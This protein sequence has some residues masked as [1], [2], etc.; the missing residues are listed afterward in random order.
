M[1]D[2]VKYFLPTQLSIQNVFYKFTHENQ[3]LIATIVHKNNIGIKAHTE[4]STGDKLS[5]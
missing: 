5:L 2:H 4:L 1:F 3:W